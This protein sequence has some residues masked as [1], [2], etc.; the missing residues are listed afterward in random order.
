MP[1]PAT[2]DKDVRAGRLFWEVFGGSGKNEKSK[3]NRALGLQCGHLGLRHT[4]EFLK[5]H[6]EQRSTN[7]ILWARPGL[8]L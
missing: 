4:G 3:Q 6:V 2:S 7:Y 1:G 5:L 8:F